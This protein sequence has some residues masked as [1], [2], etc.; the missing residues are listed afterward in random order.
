MILALG[1]IDIALIAL[2]SIILII[3]I[4]YLI[5]HKGKTCNCAFCDGKCKKQEKK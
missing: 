1:F 5:K 3:I 4:V 2:I